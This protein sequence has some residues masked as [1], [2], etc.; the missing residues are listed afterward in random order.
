MPLN[1]AKAAD[2]L[3]NPGWAWN[4]KETIK[5]LTEEEQDH[6]VSLDIARSLRQIAKDLKPIAK[7]AKTI[8]KRFKELEEGQP[9]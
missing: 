7:L 4:H 5:D 9:Q 3:T 6:M 8:E 1:F 2:E